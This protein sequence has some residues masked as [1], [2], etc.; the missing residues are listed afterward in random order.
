MNFLFL[1]IIVQI[2]VSIFEDYEDLIAAIV[3]ISWYAF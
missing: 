1:F 3:R 2:V